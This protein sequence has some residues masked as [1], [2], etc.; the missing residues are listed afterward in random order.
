MSFS[1]SGKGTK[2]EIESEP[3]T[4][5]LIITAP[6][7]LMRTLKAI[8]ARLDIRPA[9]VLIEAVIA[10][11]S[12]SK[13]NQIGIQ[14]GTKTAGNNVIPTIAGDT[15]FSSLT[16]GLGVG[17]LHNGDIRAM[18]SA[19]HRDSNVDILST[20]NIVVLDNQPAQIE[21]GKMVA[22]QT[23]AGQSNSGTDLSNFDRSFIG[24]TFKCLPAGQPR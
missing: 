9:Q 6:T 13:I 16:G 1:L 11:I 3:N 4:N 18:I 17:F 8:I 12:D 21:V 20:P 2:V 23:S 5:A 10:E 14:W 19:L 7:N 22:F 24:I 15:A